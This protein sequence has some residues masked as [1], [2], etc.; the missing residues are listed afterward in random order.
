ME[1]SVAV[2]DLDRVQPVPFQVQTVGRARLGDHAGVGD[3]TGEQLVPERLALAGDRG[4]H[5]SDGALGGVNQ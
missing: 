1:S 3:L 2:A 5:K 4:V